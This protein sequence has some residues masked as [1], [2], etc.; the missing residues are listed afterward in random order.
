MGLFIFG[1]FIQSVPFH[2]Y[3]EQLRPDPRSVLA[4]SGGQNTAW[5]GL[6]DPTGAVLEPGEHLRDLAQDKT[7]PEP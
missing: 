2:L 1:P 7:T 5:Y 4:E 3:S 6:A